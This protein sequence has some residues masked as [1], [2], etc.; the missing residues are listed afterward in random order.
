MRV[1]VGQLKAA[2]VAAGLSLAD[3]AAAATVPLADL[4][5]LEHG[6]GTA[7]TVEVLARYARA[8]GQELRL[9]VEPAK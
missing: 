5:R 7:T 9:S 6:E 8:V 3:V 4:S 1:A 2:R